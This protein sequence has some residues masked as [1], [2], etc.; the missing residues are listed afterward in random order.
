MLPDISTLKAQK[1]EENAQNGQFWMVFDKNLE[2]ECYQ[3]FKS[4]KIDE[5][6]QMRHYEWKNFIENAI[7]F[8]EFLKSYSLGSNSVTRP[9]KLP[10][11]SKKYTVC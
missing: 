10:P 5:K 2:L 8:G 3:I 9:L 7:D 4:T 6:Y 1:I 11:E